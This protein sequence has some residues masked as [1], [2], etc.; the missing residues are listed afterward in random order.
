MKPV[1]SDTKSAPERIESDTKLTPL[2]APSVRGV[3]VDDGEP[4]RDAI[5]GKLY[6]GGVGNVWQATVSCEMQYSH[7]PLKLRP[8][9]EFGVARHPSTEFDNHHNAA[10]CPYCTDNGKVVMVKA[11][12]LEKLKAVAARGEPG[13]KKLPDGCE[14]FIVN[15]GPRRS[16]RIGDFLLLDGVQLDRWCHEKESQCEFQP[17]KFVKLDPALYA[18]P[19]GA[20][21]TAHDRS[22][23]RVSIE[24]D[25]AR[26]RIKELEAE[27]AD[28]KADTADQLCVNCSDP[29]EYQERADAEAVKHWSGIV[30]KKNADAE[31]LRKA[32]K[33]AISW[34]NC[35]TVSEKSRKILLAALGSPPN[36]EHQRQGSSQA[37]DQTSTA[38][39]CNE[40][41][42]PTAASGSFEAAAEIE[43][44]TPITSAPAAESDK[45]YGLVEQMDAG[46][47]TVY[48][49]RVTVKRREEPAAGTQGNA[50]HHIEG[51][52]I[53]EGSSGSVA[54]ESEGGDWEEQCN[55]LVAETEVE[56]LE[57]C[58]E[59]YERSCTQWA[60]QCNGLI[61]ERDA[62]SARLA[63][64]EERCR[65]L[66]A[67]IRAQLG[68]LDQDQQTEVIARSLRSLLAPKAGG[69]DGK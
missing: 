35:S 17:V 51:A 6:Q 37:S 29:L 68:P 25:T 7:Q 1:A 41:P 21:R 52:K 14:G 48:G 69:E 47:G 65:E 67:G 45:P 31:R 54:A 44:N 27:L 63:T 64:C 58:I 13:L 15:D 50:Q 46:E 5:A 22:S 28:W 24:R 66:E 9:S 62:L 32:I 3:L 55:G 57:Q 4:T 11:D 23:L 53:P 26:E 43:A 18:I 10:K 34:L 39:G 8:A 42:S 60:E 59:V 61:A 12:E 2:T 49:R 30:A 20:E 38:G 19:D 36:A 40:P 33:D 56:R 16:A